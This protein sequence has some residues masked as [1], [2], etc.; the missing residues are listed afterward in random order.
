MSTQNVDTSSAGKTATFQMRIN[1]EVKKKAESLYAS[2]G[3]TLTDAVNIFIQQSLREDGLPFL[4]SPEN[5]AYLRGRAMERLMA[6][7]EKGWQSAE[8]DGWLTLDQVEE[9]LDIADA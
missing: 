9:Q 1:P 8:R 6:E 2:Y 5:E 4:M 3:L 7:V